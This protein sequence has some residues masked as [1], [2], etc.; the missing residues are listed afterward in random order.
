MKKMILSA[1]LALSSGVQ[2]EQLTTFMEIADAVSQGKKITLVLNVQECNPQKMPS[3]SLIGAV[4]PDAFLVID[5]SRITASINHFTLDNPIARGNPI[6]EFVKYTINADGSVSIKST[7]MNA[8]TYHQLASQ[9]IDCT[10][11]KGFKIFA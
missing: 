3:T 11:N 9:Y 8:V 7:L 5:N 6:F 4:Q 1:L 10:L 2:A